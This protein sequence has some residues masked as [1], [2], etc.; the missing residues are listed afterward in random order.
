[1]V[2]EDIN[3][4]IGKVILTGSL[5]K[6]DKNRMM[7]VLLPYSDNLMNLV[8][9]QKNEEL[10]QVDMQIVEINVSLE[11]TLGILW[12][13]SSGGSSSTG[14]TNSGQINLNYSETIPGGDK[15]KDLFKVGNFTRGS[16]LEATVN[17]LVQEGKARLISKPR[18]VVVSGKPASFLVGGE[19][20]IQSTTVSTTGSTLTNNTTY[21][22]YGVNL[23]VTPT[24]K[25]GKIDVLLNVDIRDV[26]SATPIS[27]SGGNVAFVTRTASTDLLLDNRQTIA[28]AGLIKYEDSVTMT[29]VPF[30][31]KLP[32]LGGFFRNRSE[33]ADSN[34][35]MI[36]IL[37]PTVLTDKKYEHKQLVMPTPEE[38]SYWN[39]ID[40]MYEHEPIVSNWPPSVQQAKPSSAE[41][42]SFAPSFP[43][44]PQYTGNSTTVN[45][46][47]IPPVD[48]VGLPATA[49]YARM[50]QEKISRAILS[51]QVLKGTMGGTVKLKLHILKDG[52]L[53]SE[54]VVQSSGN[55]TLDSDAMRAAKTAAPFAAFT[56]EMDQQDLEFTV[57]IIFN[58]LIPGNQPA[59][60]IIA[61][62]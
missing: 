39:E 49:A 42:P 21:A 32:L 34:T 23:S 11:K 60:K 26:D 2:S 6:E 8:K 14:G 33:P 52:S 55:N 12:G 22:E 18:L 27:S 20:P 57:P 51:P 15:F 62:H 41:M 1:G 48:T 53:D 25:D 16:S 38:R 54:E 5:S 36:I 4:D 31:S 7:D 47:M 50:V 10:I 30:L 17:A 40:A 13:T 24:I 46:L 44:A 59:E 35:E 43:L 37:T 19:I 3:L 56:P 58:R 29:E 9:E 61:S 45:P 28:L